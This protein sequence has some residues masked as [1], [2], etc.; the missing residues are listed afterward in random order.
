M[1]NLIEL[2]QNDYKIISVIGMS[3]NAGKTVALNEL[4]YQA[5]ESGVCIGL[6]SIGRDG[7]RQDVVTCT[8]KPTIYVE[9]GTF[10]ATAEGLFNC[11]DARLEILEITDHQTPMGRIVI[12]KVINSGNVQIAG[13][14]TNHGIREVSEKMISFGS[15]IVI[16]D[17]ALDRVSSASPSITDA[18]ILSTGAVL[19]RDMDKVIEQTA[20]RVRLFKLEKI[21][22]ESLQ[23]VVREAIDLKDNIM[24]E[25]IDDEI[26]IKT[27]DIKTALNAGKI[28]ANNMNENTR[29]VVIQG[30]LVTK[31][32]MDI[33]RQTK[34]YK[35]VKFVVK[36]ATKIFIDHRDW[37]YFNKIG[38]KLMVLDPINILAV[39][40]NPFSPMGYYF[41]PN[42]FRDQLAR[43]LDG[44][45]VFDVVHVGGL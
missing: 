34:L 20:H 14:C 16:V 12:A 7:E 6:T 30:S 43:E 17:G 31:T 27:L 25:I 37:M 21:E 35:D 18:T 41:D 2:I 11:S 10:V 3:K 26:K 42:K 4:V 33:V 45:P 24:I 39:T 36:D 15:D 28:I 22:D 13:P 1:S 8:E 38:I 23:K 9:T 40:V 44:I 32:I 5:I 19:S 29:F